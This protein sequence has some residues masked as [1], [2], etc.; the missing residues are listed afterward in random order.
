MAPPSSCPKH[1]PAH[2]CSTSRP[3]SPFTPFS[4]GRTSKARE[5]EI[6]PPGAEV[7]GRL[8]FSK[9]ITAG[10]RKGHASP[11]FSQP[12]C[13]ISRRT[14][15]QVESRFSLDEGAHLATD[16]NLQGL[17]GSEK[18]PRSA[19]GRLCFRR[20]L[21]RQ[22]LPQ[23]EDRQATHHSSRGSRAWGGPQVQERSE[24]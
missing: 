9:W 1:P 3:R 7:Q 21:P 4:R 5:N 18:E 19:V 8:T 17:P 12:C 13:Q 15:A 22:L 2:H 6:A 10:P 23:W 16:P 20:G 14:P 24:R 11:M